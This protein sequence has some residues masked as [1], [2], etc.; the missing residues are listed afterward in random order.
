MIKQKKQQPDA[1]QPKFTR[2][3]GGRDFHESLRAPF[4][5]VIEIQQREQG[6]QHERAV[7]ETLT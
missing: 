5:P 6:G 3:M 2:W 4:D 7:S 1:G